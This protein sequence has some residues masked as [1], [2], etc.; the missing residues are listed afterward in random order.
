MSPNNQSI[1]ILFIA[2]IYNKPTLCLTV[3]LSLSTI[4]Y[5]LL[6]CSQE[7]TEKQSNTFI[8]ALTCLYNTAYYSKSEGLCVSNVVS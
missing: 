8:L 4:G 7:G 6:L 3:N 2:C 1:V 5:F